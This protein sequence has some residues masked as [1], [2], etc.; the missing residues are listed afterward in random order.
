MSELCTVDSLVCG[1][2]GGIM[3][4]G[5]KFRRTGQKG[6]AFRVECSGFGVHRSA[7]QSI[8]LRNLWM[9]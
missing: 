8:Y 9:K 3:G 2:P 7:V 5:V 4:L 6:V 1:T